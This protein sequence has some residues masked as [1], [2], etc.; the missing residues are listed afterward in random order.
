MTRSVVI[1]PGGIG[2]TGGLS[3]DVANLA[4]GLVDRGWSV[5]ITAPDPAEEAFAA[6][7]GVR[8]EP[9]R[10]MGHPGISNPLGLFTGVRG[11]VRSQP[12][13]L[14]HI[15]GSMPSYLTASAF[16]AGLAER[17]RVVWTPMFHPHRARVWRTRLRYTPML[18]FDRLLPHAGR[19]ANAVATATDA[20]ATV[21]RNAGVR[22]VVTL[23][24]AVGATAMVPDEEAMHARRQLGVG[25]A[26]L[27]VVVAS[28]NEP[29]KGLSFALESFELVRRT[30]P[31]ARL[32]VVGLSEQPSRLPQGVLCPGRVPD[33]MLRGFIRAATVVFVPSLFE[34]FSRVVIEAWEQSRPL[35]VSDGVALAPRVAATGG[36]VVRYDDADGASKALVAAI[37]HPEHLAESGAL[38]RSLVET[39]YAVDR[40]VDD[41]IRTYC[42]SD[43]PTGRERVAA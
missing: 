24:P 39:E 14:L 27:I 37:T 29:R 31:D 22:T 43:V 12:G 21:F 25:N 40:V 23:P 36:R 18:I 19:L 17:R 4:A 35:V 26:P 42:G 1:V 38:G 8:V 3:I 10:R 6:L 5:T 28:R 2:G 30:R 33:T 15:F 11:I 20:E 7:S 34:A 41:A 9:V 16:A 13:A 32:A